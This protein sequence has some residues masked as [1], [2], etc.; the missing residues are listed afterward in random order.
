MINLCINPSVVCAPAAPRRCSAPGC[1][2]PTPSEP[3]SRPAGTVTRRTINVR[4]SP[5]APALPRHT[6]R[7][8]RC[9]ARGGCTETKNQWARDDPA[10]VVF[11]SLLVAIAAAA[12]CV[13]CA[14][15]AAARARLQGPQRRRDARARSFG[16][17]LGGSVLTILSAVVVDYLLLG[18]VLATI[19]W[20]A[21]RARRG[22]AAGRLL[23]SPQCRSRSQAALAVPRRRLVSNRY[24]RAAGTH[25]HA[26]EQ[27]VEWREPPR[28]WKRSVSAYTRA[29][30]SPRAR[31]CAGCTRLTCTAIRTSRSSC[32][33]T[34]CST[35]CARCCCAAA[36]S[37]CCCPTRC[38]AWRSATTTTRS[39]SA[40]AVRHRARRRPQPP[41]RRSSTRRAADARS[42]AVPGPHRVLPVPDR[43]CVAPTARTRAVSSPPAR[44]PPARR[45]CR[46]RHRAAAVHH[47]RLQPDAVRTGNLLW[48][49]A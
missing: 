8:R 20:R 31:A 29:H 39:S 32:S 36:S 40:T 45:G 35:S 34:S 10:F 37:R 13:A 43:G 47:E 26:V 42:A 22:P 25:S 2:S 21:P 28:P 16:D 3:R 27:R 9:R 38:T 1:P 41:R 33:S 14:P 44:E 19:G 49:V 24:L 4:R 15:S 48:R 30:L 17:G 11:S 7:R 12:Y 5:L 18:V 6:P 46:Y 23:T